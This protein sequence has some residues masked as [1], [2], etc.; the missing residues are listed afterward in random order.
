MGTTVKNGFSSRHSWLLLSI[1]LGG[2]VSHLTAGVVNVALPGL[3]ST[4][5]KGIDIVQWITTGYLLVIVTLLPLMGKLGD[6]WGHRRVHN[7]GYILFALGSI[8]VAL[9]PN[10]AYLL[11]FRTFQAIGAAMFQAT[12]IALITM[13]TPVDQRGKGLGFLGTAVALGALSGPVVGGFVYEWMGWHWLFLIHVPVIIIA[14]LLANRYIPKDLSGKKTNL[15]GVGALI[16]A[17]FIGLVVFGVSSGHSLGWLSPGILLSILLGMFAL[18]LLLK[19]ESNQNEPFLPLAILRHPMVA[20]GIVISIFTFLTAFST[21]VVLPFYLI[22]VMGLTT[23]ETGYLMM[24]YPLA[25]AIAGPVAGNLSDRHGSARLT[26][27]GLALMS[28]ASV[29]LMVI[30]TGPS[31]LAFLFILAILGL[32]M[33]LVTSPNYSLIMKFIP[34]NHVGMAGGIIA[35]SRNLGMVF[36]AAIGLGFMQWQDV[37]AAGR[38][39]AVPGFQI[40]FGINTILC[41]LCITLFLA[42]QRISKRE[43]N[44]PKGSKLEGRGSHVV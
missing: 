25:L 18:W 8:F 6:R 10:L 32:G 7:T 5:D 37:A 29:V 24:A 43:V 35:L 22:K 27:V 16:F 23:W 26:L 20:V 3:S 42:G 17:V 39:V 31:L 14:F 4:F 11:V 21:Q 40:V 13:H 15:D 38:P 19:W 9:S 34:K 12:N 36:G 41:L 30:Q 33:G 1:C 2:F 28:L 44:K